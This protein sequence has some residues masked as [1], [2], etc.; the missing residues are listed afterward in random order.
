MIDK[1]HQHGFIVQ[2]TNRV[3]IDQIT[4]GSFDAPYK[5]LIACLTKVK[6]HAILITILEHSAS[7]RADVMVFFS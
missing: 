1:E 6:A 4:F 5:S 7:Q 2:L 3:K